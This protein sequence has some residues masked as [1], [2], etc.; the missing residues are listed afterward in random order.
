MTDPAPTDALPVLYSFRRC[1]YAIRARMALAASGTVVV[2]R[3]VRLRD[4]PAA[5]LALLP[6]GTVPVLQRPDGGVLD[7]SLAIMRWALHRN[8]PQQ[9]LGGDAQA[10]EVLI[11]DNDERFKP[12]LDRYK[13]SVRYPE[14]SQQDHRMQ[15]ETVLRQWE[16]Q[17]TRFTGGLTCAQPRL[18]D[19]A[20]FP[21]VRQ[22]AG[23]EPAWWD[24][25]P[26]PQ[27]QAW[28][29]RWARSSVFERVMLNVAPWHA[30]AAP[31]TIDWQ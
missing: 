8:D 11:Q 27:L 1:P 31:V 14:Q 9:W 29:G 28:L 19:V 4:K 5:M 2:L 18:A 20:L 26:Y 23:V 21:F 22:F 16:G 7:E 3:E 25:A 12:L 24:S 17:L 15:A 13:Y 30:A 6:K 10:S